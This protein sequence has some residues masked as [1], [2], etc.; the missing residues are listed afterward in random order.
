MK[1]Q[2]HSSTMNR[3]AKEFRGM[4]NSDKQEGC[5]DLNDNLQFF[6][7]KVLGVKLVIPGYYKALDMP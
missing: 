5:K 4:T 2:E 6:Q 7:G 3:H 1:F